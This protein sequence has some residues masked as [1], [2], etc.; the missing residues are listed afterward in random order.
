MHAIKDGKLKGIPYK[1]ARIIGGPIEPS[2]I[3]IHDTAGRLEPGSS[4]KWFQDK[5]CKV[6]AHFV[7][8][9]DGAVTQMVP[10]DRKAAHAGTSEW[11]GR[12]FCNSFSIGIEVVNPGSLDKTGK[13][14]FGQK[15]PDVVPMATA[16]HGD[17]CWLPYTEEQ[18]DAV[19]EICRSICEHYPSVNEIVGHWQISPGRKVDPNP[20]FPWDVVCARVFEEEVAAPPPDAAPK[21]MVTSKEGAA[22][23]VNSAAGGGIAL[24]GA[25]DAANKVVEKA[26]STGKAPGMWDIAA[27]VLQSTQVKIGVGIMIAAALSW[28][29]RAQKRWNQNI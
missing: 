9:V 16:E 20:L 11:S 8:E 5:S 13:A 28:F 1:P 24:D 19:I 12:K 26:A 18:I 27:G 17:A 21:S 29:W 6:S 10:V 15:F 23:V 25:W 4:V 2:L 14:W 7:V 3:V 22:Q